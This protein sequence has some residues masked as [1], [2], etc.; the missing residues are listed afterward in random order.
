MQIRNY[1]Q[2]DA[3][4]LRAVFVSSVRELAR[5]HYTAEQI[6]A[7]APARWDQ[8]QW[9]QRLAGNQPFVA[10]VDGTIA[11]FADLQG[12]GYIDQFFVAAAFA[13]RGV[14]A[15]LMQHLLDAASRQCLRRLYSNVSL[16]AEAFFT[17]HGFQLVERQTVVVRGVQLANA[18]MEKRLADD[19]SGPVADSD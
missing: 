4:A 10:V 14:G 13:R 9:R 5:Q 18:R 12:S 7:W 6:D 11:G 15:A 19:C 16:A 1:S 17:R 8:A 2:D 3:D